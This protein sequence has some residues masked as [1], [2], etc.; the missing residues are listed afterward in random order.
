MKGLTMYRL[1]IAVAAGLLPIAAAHAKSNWQGAGWYQIVDYIE[2]GNSRWKSIY[3]GPYGSEADCLKSPT[4]GLRRSR[5]RGGRPRH[6]ER[7]L[8]CAVEYPP[9]L[10]R[11]RR[12]ASSD[13]ASATRRCDFTPAAGR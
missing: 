5:R 1:F 8:V 3:N 13:T 4:P 12:A 11:V 6:T 10:G 9:G 2:L 7:L